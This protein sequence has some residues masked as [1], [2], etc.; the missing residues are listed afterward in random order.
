MDFYSVPKPLDTDMIRIPAAGPEPCNTLAFLRCKFDWTDWPPYVNIDTLRIG[1]HLVSRFRIDGFQQSRL[2]WYR[3]NTHVSATARLR[4]LA[5]SD[6]MTFLFGVESISAFVDP[7]G[8]IG[9]S[10][11]LVADI[12][13]GDLGFQLDISAWVLCYEP[14][15]ELPPSGD[16][17]NR[18]DSWSEVSRATVSRSLIRSDA[19]KPPRRAAGR[20]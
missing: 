13:P 19:W 3:R 11:G 9:F 8:A 14:R 10:C 12:E 20:R 16:S 5:L 17:G 2:D 18:L 6:D 7:A 1:F 4:T 15:V